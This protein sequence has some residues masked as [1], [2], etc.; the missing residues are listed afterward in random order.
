MSM[1]INDLIKRKERLE[2]RLDFAL[3]I[4]DDGTVCLIESEIAAV[5]KEIEGRTK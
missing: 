5:T 1:N 4:D 2:K 3:S